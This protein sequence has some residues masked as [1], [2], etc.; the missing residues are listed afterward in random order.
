MSRRTSIVNKLV[1]K[2]KLIDGTGSF[3]SNLYG[4]AYAQLKFWD[5]CLNFPSIYVTPGQE[6]REYHPGEF[7]WGFLNIC[8]KVYVK[9]PENT[10]QQLENLIEDIESVIDSNRV[11]V[12]DEVNSYE[13]TEILIQSI[14]TD[15]GLLLPYGVGEVTIQVRYPIM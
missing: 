8:I 2:L 14:V 11:L 12:Y 9:D 6:S 10:Q 5:E 4:N 3:K 7:K 13:T 15:E 1:D